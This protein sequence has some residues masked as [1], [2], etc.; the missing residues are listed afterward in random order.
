MHHTL[1]CHSNPQFT[2]AHYE[3]FL[4]TL[5]RIGNKGKPVLLTTE[6]QKAYWKGINKYF[7]S[8]NYFPPEEHKLRITELH[9]QASRT[10]AQNRTEGDLDAT[11]G[12][13]CIPLD[14]HDFIAQLL[15]KRGGTKDIE[16]LLVLLLAFPL[17]WRINKVFGINLDGNHVSRSQ[18]ALRIWLFSSKADKQGKLKQQVHRYANHKIQSG[19]WSRC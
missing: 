4:H 2:T 17:F 13:D 5:T 14:L 11:S 12:A 8:I 16:I 15:F 6:G 7:R 9:K 10:E 18:D 1:W 3:L 19:A